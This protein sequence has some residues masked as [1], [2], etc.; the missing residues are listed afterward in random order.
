MDSWIT[1]SINDN[2]RNLSDTLKPT[3]FP[4]RHQTNTGLQ[5]P[6]PKIDTTIQ[7]DEPS[8]IDGSELFGLLILV[9]IAAVWWFFRD[10][11]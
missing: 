8:W 10:R 4:T 7:F 2:L 6:T 11:K 9:T 5:P 3:G 1:N